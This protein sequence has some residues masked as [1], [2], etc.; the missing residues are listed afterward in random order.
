M[1]IQLSSFHSILFSKSNLGVGTSDHNTCS[2]YLIFGILFLR[3][4]RFQLA[5]VLE[6]ATVRTSSFSFAR[7]F[8][9]I[10]HF[11]ENRKLS[12][13]RLFKTLL[14]FLKILMLLRYSAYQ[15][16]Q[17]SHIGDVGSIASNHNRDISARVARRV[18][19]AAAEATT[20]AT[21]GCTWRHSENLHSLLL[22]ATFG[23]QRG[24]YWYFKSAHM[25][26]KQCT[27]SCPTEHCCQP[28]ASTWVDVSY[29]L[30]T[31]GTNTIIII[32][33]STKFLFCSLS[34]NSKQLA[35]VAWASVN[36]RHSM[37]LSFTKLSI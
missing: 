20:E 32:K 17:R 34:V 27:S 5:G 15:L 14:S 21:V 10:S 28:G 13:W 3:T 4:S 23:F 11:P 26:E 16:L 8:A 37:I 29:F 33:K 36:L 12:Y 25:Y 19:L 9:C 18:R 1:C 24:V 7:G 35:W 22:S 30:R 31:L 6:I 2:C